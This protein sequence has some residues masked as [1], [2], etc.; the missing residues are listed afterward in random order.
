[1]NK[2]WALLAGIFC[3]ISSTAFSQDTSNTQLDSSFVANSMKR[4]QDVY[5][6]YC[7]SCHQM[8]GVG[9]SETYPPLANADYLKTLTSNKLINIILKGQTDTISVNGTSY[10]LAMDAIG[11]LSDDQVADVINFIRNSWGNKTD[12]LVTSSQ[13]K[14]AR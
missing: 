11:Y 7:L 2:K 5:I 12:S 6:T 4:G 9:V 1:M 14:A 10:S 3:C 8:G 13:V